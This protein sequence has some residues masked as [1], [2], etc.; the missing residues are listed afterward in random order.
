[1]LLAIVV[2]V[3]LIAV[4]G[5][6]SLLEFALWTLLIAAAVVALAVFAVGRLLADR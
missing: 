2:I 5:I 1:M 6:G 4:F 3:L